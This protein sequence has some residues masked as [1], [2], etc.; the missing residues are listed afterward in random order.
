MEISPAELATTCAESL[1]YGVFLIFFKLA[2]YLHF[3]QH[4]KHSGSGFRRRSAPLLSP[5]VLFS[6]TIFLSLTANW[7]IS[8]VVLSHRDADGQ[9]SQ[10]YQTLQNASRVVTLDFGDITMVR[11]KT[12]DPLPLPLDLTIAVDLSLCVEHIFFFYLKNIP[13]FCAALL[14]TNIYYT[15]LISWRIWD[16]NKYTRRYS[17]GSSLLHVVSLIVD[18]AVVLTSWTIFVLLADLHDLS[19][20]G[21]V[22]TFAISTLAPI[23]AVSV[24]SISARVGLGWDYKQQEPPSLH[25]DPMGSLRFSNRLGEQQNSA[26][27][28]EIPRLSQSHISSA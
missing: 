22:Y 24:I 18:S 27:I 26:V 2:I 20:E 6:F 14:F 9:I 11:S 7:I 3:T 28:V 25:L 5:M 17:E 1:L 21:G 15:A 16:T 4:R 13:A 12:F 19:A 8:N 10:T 23:S